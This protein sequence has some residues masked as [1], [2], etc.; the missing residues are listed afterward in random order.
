MHVF[1]EE[2]R[3]LDVDLGANPDKLAKGTQR[4]RSSS[5]FVVYIRFRILEGNP[6]RRSY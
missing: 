6:N 1:P 2:I 3:P 5:L 4:L